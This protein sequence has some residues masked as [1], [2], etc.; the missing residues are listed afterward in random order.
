MGG[1]L[2][3]VP[4]EVPLL[5][6][7]PLLG[8][9]PLEGGGLLLDGLAP[10]GGGGRAL[11]GGSC[12]GTPGVPPPDGGGGVD[13]PLPL[14]GEPRDDPEAVTPDEADEVLDMGAPLPVELKGA[15]AL[16]AA[17]FGGPPRT[18]GAGPGALG[19]GGGPSDMSLL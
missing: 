18:T 8:G 11:L 17:L 9:G 14:R 1:P 19:G 3:G 16:P 2:E 4:G 15:L 13:A 7:P 12:L 5:I 10:G 6:E